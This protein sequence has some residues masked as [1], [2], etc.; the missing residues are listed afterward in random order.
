MSLPKMTIKATEIDKMD[1]Y[2]E[3]RLKHAIAGQ[4]PPADSKEHL[5]QSASILPMRLGTQVAHRLT[6]VMNEARLIDIYPPIDLSQKLF[7]W[8]MLSAFRTGG[9]DIACYFEPFRLPKCN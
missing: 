8:T 1:A 5:L 2:L 6:L 4:R 7:G 9:Q 3:R